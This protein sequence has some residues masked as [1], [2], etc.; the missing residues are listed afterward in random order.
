VQG[1]AGP[2]CL[3]LPEVW[4]WS[5]S[6]WL[7]SGAASVLELVPEPWTRDALGQCNLLFVTALPLLGSAVPLLGSRHESDRRGGLRLA[8]D[9]LRLACAAPHT[10]RSG[11]ELHSKLCAQVQGNYT[12]SVLSAVDAGLQNTILY[13]TSHHI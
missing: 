4:T 6:G 5:C 9:C 3:E 12:R 2:C 10:P 13:R 8:A 7:Q 11:V 1:S